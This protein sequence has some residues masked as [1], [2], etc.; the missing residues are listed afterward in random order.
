MN[1]W[2]TTIIVGLL[3]LTFLI[4]APFETAGAAAGV[5]CGVMLGYKT[6]IGAAVSPC[7]ELRSKCPRG[8]SATMPR[9]NPV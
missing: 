3:A 4:F 9:R 6:G 8:M 1:F 5:V 7:L 2:V